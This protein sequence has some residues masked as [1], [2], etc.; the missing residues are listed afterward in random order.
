M[1]DKKVSVIMPVYNVERYIERSVYSI[2][3]QTYRNLEIILVDD[4][5]KDNS[6]KLCDYFAQ[7]DN[8]IKVLHKENG[9]LSSARNA[10]LALASGVYVYFF[11][12]DDYIRNDTIE[13]CMRDI[14]DADLLSFGFETVN[15][16]GNR[17]VL[18]EFTEGTFKLESEE[19]TLKFIINQL[20]KYRVA[21]SVWSKVFSMSVIQKNN[22]RFVN[23]NIIFAED[24]LFTIMYILCCKE[25]KCVNKRYYHYLIR[26][27]SIMNTVTDTKLN[28]M[29]RLGRYLELYIKDMRLNYIYDNYLYVFHLIIDNHLKSV[30]ANSLLY[31]L[32]GISEDNYKFLCNKYRIN[33]SDYKKS[34]KYLGIKTR[35]ERVL[36]GKVFIDKSEVALKILNIIRKIHRWYS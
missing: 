9:G 11:D 23:N 5:S 30:N 29:I 35:F 6:G 12:S 31:T 17:R 8:R 7:I 3:N 21:W 1:C 32:G 4:G 27:D 13:S 25:I 26:S 10:G 14:C 22:L 16:N 18:M 20:F 2:I 19:K 34:K 36:Y 33:Y 28:E 15:E 24:I